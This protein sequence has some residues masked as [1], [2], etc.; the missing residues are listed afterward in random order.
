MGAVVDIESENSDLVDDVVLLQ[1]DATKMAIKC[2]ANALCHV[3]EAVDAKYLKRPLGKYY[4]AKRVICVLFC[5]SVNITIVL[6][7][8]E[9]QIFANQN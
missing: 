7:N 2:L 1:A 9:N 6:S 4:L 5:I 8:P 3:A